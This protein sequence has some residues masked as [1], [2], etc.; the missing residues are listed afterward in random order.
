MSR[1][2]FVGDVTVSSSFL[3]RTVVGTVVETFFKFKTLFSVDEEVK[4]GGGDKEGEEI[5]DDDDDDEDNLEA[6]EDGNNTDDD[7]ELED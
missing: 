7:V 4:D 6:G 5:V 3:F 2:T 1:D